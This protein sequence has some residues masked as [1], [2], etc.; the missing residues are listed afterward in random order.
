MTTNAE[1]VLAAAE[2]VL[3]AIRDGNEIYDILVESFLTAIRTAVDAD[4][5]DTAADEN[6]ATTATA[7]LLNTLA[8][9]GFSI[10]RFTP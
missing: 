2:A 9:A 6:A 5:V 1:A 8:D 3:A 10:T 7:S 4:S